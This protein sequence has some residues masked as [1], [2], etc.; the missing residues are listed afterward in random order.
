MSGYIRLKL[1]S[2]ECKF[3]C[4]VLKLCNQTHTLTAHSQ[5]LDSQRGRVVSGNSSDV[6]F[7]T[8]EERGTEAREERNSGGDEVG[9]D[10][11]EEEIKEERS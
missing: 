7:F 11:R 1:K 3:F 2:R 6:F 4:V 9:G 8:R 5:S 10:E